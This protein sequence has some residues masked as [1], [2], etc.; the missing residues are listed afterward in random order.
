MKHA[1]AL[2]QADREKLIRAGFTIQYPA[3]QTELTDS[4]IHRIRR[5]MEKRAVK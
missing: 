5:R 4:Q 3:K 2:T 1:N